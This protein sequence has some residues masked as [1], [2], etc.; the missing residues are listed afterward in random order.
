[1]VSP[2]HPVAAVVTDVEG[3]TSAIDFVH[4][5]LFPYARDTLPTWL[6]AH[7]QDP[8]VAHW[9]EQVVAEA[10]LPADG[11]GVAELLQGWIDADRKHTALKALQGMIWREAFE[12]GQFRSHVYPDA[13]FQL[14]HWH[15]QGLPLYVYS[16]GSVEAQRLYFRHTA[17]GDL[18]ALF[19][20]HF[21]TTT[22]PKRAAD[23]YR[24]I[25]AAIGCEATGVLFLSDIEAELDAASEA[26]WQCIQIVRAGTTA[27]DRHPNV[28]RLDEIEL[29][30]PPA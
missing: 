23:S 24:K 17:A 22:G 21:D 9:V 12:S 2:V 28:S 5:V 16:S 30:A 11:E 27:S 3:T 18:S 10:G 26:G 1:M 7:R 20:G 13:V 19:Q 8:E 29:A 6:V 4:E 14:R 25:A 15:A